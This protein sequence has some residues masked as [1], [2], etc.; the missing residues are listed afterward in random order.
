[1]GR[2]LKQTDELWAVHETVS[3]AE[4]AITPG[5]KTKQELIDHLVKHGTEWDEPWTQAQAETF[6]N[7][8]GWAPSFVAN[9]AKKAFCK[10]Y[11]VPPTPA[12][13]ST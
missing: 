7:G 11:E 2:E 4:A 1:M 9:P 10:G 3:E 5:F 8:T 12:S 13:A 6:V